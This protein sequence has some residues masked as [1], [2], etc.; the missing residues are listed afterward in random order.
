MENNI[1][2]QPIQDEIKLS[3]YLRIVLQYRYLIVMI[4]VFV[5]AGTIFYTARQ[6][7]IYSATSRI[8]LEDQN[9]N[10]GFL[11]MATPG[12]GRNSINN[13][14]ELIK[15]KPTLSL[16]WEIMKK[17]PDWDLFP[18]A[19]LANPP[20]GLANV[21]VESKRDTDLLTI[22][23]ES[24]SPIEAQAAVNAVAE[25]I[26]QQNTQFA[27]LEF[28]TIREFLETQLDAI[29]RRLQASE[30]DLREFKNLNRLTELSTE[31]VKLIEQSSELEAELESALTEMAVKAKS[32]DLLSKQLRDQDSLMVDVDNII[33]TPYLVELRK[34]VVETQALIT[35]LITKNEYPLDHPQIIL[36]NRELENTRENLDR[37][38]KKLISVTVPSDPLSTRSDLVSRIIQASIDLELARTRVNGLEQTKE[39]YEQRIISLPNTELELARL[40]RNMMLD[41]KIHGIM[42]EKY[43][44]AKIA[45]QAKV[46]NIRIIDYAN[47][48][49]IPIKPR[50]SMNILV[51]IILGL[52][53]GVGFA[54]IVHS[55]DTKLRTLEDMEGF[56]RLPIVGTIP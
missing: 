46:G 42:M 52:G 10:A 39:M 11:M 21:S 1:Q 51:G 5:M 49:T 14:I 28:T 23:I 40:S 18:I 15:S 33:Q 22:S 26:Q 53:L 47:R 32:L 48:P 17:Y 29:S 20:G 31:T 35:K 54:F 30:N 36:L 27:R 38:V 19:S 24:T 34:Q 43:E 55:M 56:V 4:F 44:D 7:K 16:A 25:A 9:S 2:N 13:Q 6:P 12:I 45:E 41:S 50:V 8:L 3:D 37:E